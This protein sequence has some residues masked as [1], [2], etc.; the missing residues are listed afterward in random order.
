MIFSGYT[1]LAPSY[2]NPYSI[3]TNHYHVYTNRYGA[4]TN[5]HVDPYPVD[6]RVMETNPP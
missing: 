4:R 5:S 2:T 1:N 3:Y 6:P